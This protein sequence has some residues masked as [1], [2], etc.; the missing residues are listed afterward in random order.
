MHAEDTIG[1][2][3]HPVDLIP[4]ALQD[5]LEVAHVVMLKILRRAP[6]SLQ[7]SMMLM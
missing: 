5:P 3:E 2:D 1:D 6:E 4:Q 7:P